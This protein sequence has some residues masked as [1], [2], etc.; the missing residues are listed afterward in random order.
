MALIALQARLDSVIAA[1][2]LALRCCTTYVPGLAGGN[3]SANAIT[4]LVRQLQA[5][6]DAATAYAADADLQTY[7]RTQLVTPSFDILAIIAGLQGLVTAAIAAAKATIPTDGSGYL[8]K[9][10]WAA[11]GTLTVRALTPGQTAALVTAL[12]AIQTAIPV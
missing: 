12:Q 7:C 4:D 1:R 5:A 8:L 9:D 3:N 11:D 10:Q 2:D 6:Y